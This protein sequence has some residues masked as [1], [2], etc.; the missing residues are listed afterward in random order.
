MKLVV[1]YGNFQSVR[2]AKYLWK[3]WLI[4]GLLGGL[5]GLLIRVSENGDQIELGGPIRSTVSLMIALFLFCLVRNLYL[6]TEFS[7]N[8]ILRI[9]D[10]GF[11]IE[12]SLRHDWSN[13]D[14]VLVYPDGAVSLCFKGSPD[15]QKYR[16]IFSVCD[17]GLVAPVDEVLSITREAKGDLLKVIHLKGS[18]SDTVIAALME[19]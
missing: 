12:F 8:G 11:R 15:D 19:K 5:F 13:L 6:K 2:I 9:F 17:T 16:S 10:F 14:R 3:G 4:I 1:P 18:D 7:Q